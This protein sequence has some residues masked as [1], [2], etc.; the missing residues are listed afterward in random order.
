MI[1]P[2]AEDPVNFLGVYAGY[3]T[4]PRPVKKA[5]VYNGT[6]YIAP[7]KRLLFTEDI[8]SIAFK[9]ILSASMIRNT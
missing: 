1:G 3:F 2:E 8:R 6:G 7:G 5:E 9:R 4:F